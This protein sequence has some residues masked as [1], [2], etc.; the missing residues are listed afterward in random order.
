MLRLILTCHSKVLIP[1]ECGFI[2]W[3]KNKYA[4]WSPLDTKTKKLAEFLDD[5]FLCKKF[6][7]WK[8]DRSFIESHVISCQPRDYSELCRV[9]FSAYG[10]ATGKNF[11]IWGDKNNF[12]VN[13]ISDLLELYK[14]ARFLHIVRDGR[15]VACS[16]RSAM[17]LKTTSPYAPKLKTDI[18]SIANEWAQNVMNVNA[19]I[20]ALPDSQSM[21]IR[22]EDLTRM[23]VAT[24]EE[25]CTW[26]NICYEDEMLKFY[27]HNKAKN[28]E[29]ILTIDWKKM[30][31]EKISTNSIGRYKNCLSKYEIMR[32]NKIAGAALKEF[33][34]LQ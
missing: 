7:T 31:T 29:P 27:L 12:H 17:Q 2:I 15:D 11:S 8:L 14:H 18:T 22:Y 13:H 20:S 33:N 16:Y 30:T 28:L 5:L 4:T 1:P 10:D 26:L 23:S 6:E 21:T 3:L 9:V 19:I 24:I 25:I 34:Y 32:F